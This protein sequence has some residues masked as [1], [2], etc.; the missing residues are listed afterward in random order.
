[1]YDVC[2][3]L[4]FVFL[5]TSTSVFELIYV[6]T[7]QLIVYTTLYTQLEAAALK[8]SWCDR[9]LGVVPKLCDYCL[10]Q[11]E[12]LP[13]TLEAAGKQAIDDKKKGLLK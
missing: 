7:Y 11:V 10:Q 5:I 4:L 3:S 2:V 1:M 9:L 6:S 13:E 8:S 12:E